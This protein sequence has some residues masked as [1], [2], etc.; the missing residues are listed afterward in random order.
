MIFDGWELVFL[1][2]VNLV[3]G[4]VRDEG[5][6]RQVSKKFGCHFELAQLRSGEESLTRKRMSVLTCQEQYKIKKGVWNN[7]CVQGSTTDGASTSDKPDA[8]AAVATCIRA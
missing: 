5:F 4:V 7:D 8:P 2:P 3:R 1:R 6:I